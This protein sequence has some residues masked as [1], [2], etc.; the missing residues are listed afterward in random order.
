MI[1]ILESV[2]QE[3]ERRTL[4]SLLLVWPIWEQFLGDILKSQVDSMYL[5]I[6]WPSKRKEIFFHRLMPQY[7]QCLAHVVLTGSEGQACGGCSCLLQ[8]GPAC[9]PG[10]EGRALP[11]APRCPEPRGLPRSTA[12]WALRTTLGP[13]RARPLHPETRGVLSLGVLPQFCP[14]PTLTLPSLGP[15]GSVSRHCGW[16]LCEGL[17]AGR[18]VLQRAS[19]QSPAPPACPV[20]GP[21]PDA[22]AAVR[23]GGRLQ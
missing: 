19:P 20:R 14:A 18:G 11:R 2:K 1:R 13:T 10:G 5:G 21:L 6:V 22:E 8:G 16:S 23:T 17:G 7:G 15:G 4:L 12:S 3:R 9:G